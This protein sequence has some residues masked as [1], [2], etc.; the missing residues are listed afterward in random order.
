MRKEKLSWIYLCEMKLRV[1]L[2]CKPYYNKIEFIRFFLYTCV[3]EI[4]RSHVFG[5]TCLTIFNIFRIYLESA[6]NAKE[7][8]LYLYL[9]LST[10]TDICLGCSGQVY[11]FLSSSGSKSTSW[12]MKQSKILSFRASM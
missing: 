5:F 8:R 9:N 12:K 2:T 1:I 10:A 3:F 4:I 6:V 7:S 11:K